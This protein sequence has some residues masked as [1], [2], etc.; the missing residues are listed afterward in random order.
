MSGASLLLL[1]F[2]ASA[3]ALIVE[4]ERTA[5]NEFFDGLTCS[6]CPRVGRAEDCP[7]LGDA[8]RCSPDGEPLLLP[9]APAAGA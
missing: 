1:A 2:A 8:L 4:T 9:H 3:V 6:A 7:M 5:L